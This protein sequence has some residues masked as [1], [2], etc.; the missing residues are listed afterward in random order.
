MKILIPIILLV[1]SI[2]AFTQKKDEIKPL[3]IKTNLLITDSKN[4]FANDVKQED[5]KVFEDGVEQKITYFAKKTSANV[6]FVV[7]NTGSMRT[8]LEIILD[9]GNL[10]AANLSDT[11]SAFV[12]RFVDSSKITV[13][14]DW[15]SNKMLLKRAFAGMYVEGGASAVA[16]AVYL[17]AEKLNEKKKDETTKNII[18][19]ISDCDDRDSF[20]K[21]KQV[22]EILKKSNVQVL[23]LA[24]FDALTPEYTISANSKQNAQNLA[25]IFAVETN[26][27]VFLLKYSKKDKEQLIDTIKKVVYEIRSQYEIGYTSTNLKQKD[28]ERKI[29]VEV[30]ND[31]KGE[32][33]LV[34]MR[35]K[36][37]LP[38]N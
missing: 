23:V 4:L 33:R 5:L 14:Q 32:K 20:Y 3:E 10:V 7:D 26:G 28:V 37:V 29:V 36:I 17:A 31:S 21:Q 15:T 8:Q 18:V 2:T 22:I 13:E 1:F 38:K 34:F 11:D 35:D 12:V 6:G 9:T 25:N 30:A 16:D 19:L 27:S 24:F